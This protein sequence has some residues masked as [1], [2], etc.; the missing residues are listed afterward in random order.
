MFIAAGAKYGVDPKDLKALAMKESGLNPN[1]VG[2]V[3]PNGTQDFG[4]MQHNSKY[5]AARGLTKETAMD[6]ATAIDK[7]A[8][9]MAQNLKAAG[10]DKRD[11]FRRYNGS[12]P[13][14]EAYANDVMRI[15]GGVGDLTPMPEGAP[16]DKVATTNVQGVISGGIDVRVN[17]QPAARI[18][19]QTELRQ[20]QPQGSW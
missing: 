17:G 10:G 5:L 11:A 18:P 8:E 3:N 9:L 20:A 6:P 2:A 13:A 16:S 15:R 14:A 1:A 7:A 4:L 12:G 19:V